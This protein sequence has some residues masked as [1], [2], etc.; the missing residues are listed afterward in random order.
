MYVRFVSIFFFFFFVQ[1]NGLKNRLCY[2]RARYQMHLV[3]RRET[4]TVTE[5]DEEHLE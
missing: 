4:R 1:P 2:A 5:Q 3:Y